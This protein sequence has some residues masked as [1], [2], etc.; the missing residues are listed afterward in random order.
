MDEG[1][2]VMKVLVTGCRDWDETH[3][4]IIHRELA[5]LP[6]G[7]IVIHGACRGVDTIAGMIAEAL[8]FVVR[9]YPARW[10]VLGRAAGPLRN[11]QMLIEEHLP[12][13]PIDKVL[14]FHHDIDSS[15][16]TAGMK[17]LAE[18]WNIET[19]LVSE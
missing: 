12:N 13:E 1:R 19:K 7:T 15:N 5:Q 18:S 3:V 8:G 14:V 10:D 2:L 11:K 17:K 4:D 9:S 6:P 16:G